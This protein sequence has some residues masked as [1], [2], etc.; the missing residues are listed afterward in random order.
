MKTN[1]NLRKSDNPGSRPGEA[2]FFGRVHQA[3]IWELARGELGKPVGARGTGSWPHSKQDGV[4]L[5]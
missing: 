1:Q 4:W 3:G 2:A 5:A